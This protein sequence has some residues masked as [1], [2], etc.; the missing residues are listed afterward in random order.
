LQHCTFAVPVL[1]I[2]LVRV[3]LRFHHHQSDLEGALARNAYEQRGEVLLMQWQQV[4]MVDI[5]D[6]LVQ[7]HEQV[8]DKMDDMIVAVYT[9]V[10]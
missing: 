2:F 9:I 1:A 8:L 10:H 4:E 3:I 6:W 5:N 7:W